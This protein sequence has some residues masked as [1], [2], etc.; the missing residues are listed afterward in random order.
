MPH[1]LFQ[2]PSA[3]FSLEPSGVSGMSSL[4]VL[5]QDDRCQSLQNSLNEYTEFWN[6]MVYNDS[7]SLLLLLG[8]VWSSVGIP[9][10]GGISDWDP[11]FSLASLFPS[12]HH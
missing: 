11:L 2:S 12:P 8:T 10:S 3:N 4:F 9:P 1:A 6:Q 5:F 7:L